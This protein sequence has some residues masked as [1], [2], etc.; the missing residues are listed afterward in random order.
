MT[1][2]HF[3]FS[4]A[5]LFQVGPIDMKAPNGTMLKKEDAVALFLARKVLK[6]V[7]IKR[8]IPF[9]LEYGRFEHV[10]MV[11]LDYEA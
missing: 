1:D 4:C 3:A 2:V 6:R 8:A 5:L 9:C 11:S 7:G 10:V